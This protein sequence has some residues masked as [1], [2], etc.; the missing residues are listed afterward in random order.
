V[1]LKVLALAGRRMIFFPTALSQEH[2]TTI[3]T[4]QVTLTSTWHLLN[5]QQA[6]TVFRPLQQDNLINNR[7]Q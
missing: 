3:Q 7:K 5:I 2:Q 6:G 1:T 4:D